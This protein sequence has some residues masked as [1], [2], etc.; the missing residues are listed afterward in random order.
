MLSF[1]LGSTVGRLITGGVVAVAAIV[2]WILF[3]PL[4]IDRQVSES[5][6]TIEAVMEMSDADKAEV[7]D[8]MLT[9]AAGEADTMMKDAMP[10]EAAMP[11]GPVLL[12]QTMFVDADAVHQGSGDAKVFDLG[13]GN[14]VLRFE[15]FRVTNGPDLKVWLTNVDDPKADKRDIAKDGN[16]VALG[17]LKGNVGDQNYEIPAEVDL[18]EFNHVVIWCQAFGVLFSSATLNP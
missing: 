16:W 8:D 7:M 1:F 10:E 12:N 9:A 11:T 3:S 6:P 17:A 5:F 4:F 18:S 15:N 13:D 2:A 14:R